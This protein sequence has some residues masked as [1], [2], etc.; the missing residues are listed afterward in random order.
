MSS[1]KTINVN[2]D[3][4][5]L[6]PGGRK[7][8][9]KTRKK[10]EKK[11]KPQTLVKPNKL[12]K[13]LL[14]RIKD[15]QKNNEENNKI[16]EVKTDIQEF[17]NEFQESLKYLESLAKNKKSI[18]R[19]KSER[20]K[21]QKN[22]LMPPVSNTVPPEMNIP[23]PISQTHITAT[24]E[25]DISHPSTHQTLRIK[26]KDNPPYSNLK[27]GSRPTYREWK[28]KQDIPS[29][30]I[31]DKPEV[32]PPTERSLKLTEVKQAYQEINPSK[33]QTPKLKRTVRTLKYQLGKTKDQI[34]V[35]IKSRK[36]RKLVQHEHA[37]LKQKSILEIKNYLRGKNLIKS[38]SNAP[39]DVLRQIYEQA[40]LTGEVSNKSKENLLHNFFNDK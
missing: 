4:F 32:L 20:R 21:T 37:L 10:R 26:H 13:Q 33:C 14:S 15:F 22:K 39:N 11:Q 12:R 19:E 8:D 5:S 36:T 30:T 28:K 18:K 34:A 24:V 3:F 25:T 6:T 2:P 29:I 40:I 38:G 16:L 31:E 23:L 35:L 17:D 27:N 7:K 9:S 1:Q